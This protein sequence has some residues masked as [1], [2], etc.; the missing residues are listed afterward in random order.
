MN[1]RSESITPTRV[2]SE[3]VVETPASP[4]VLDKAFIRRL[5][6]SDTTPSVLNTEA[7]VCQNTGAVTVTDFSE[8]ATGQHLYMRGDGFTTVANNAN[9]K[10]N[11]GANKLLVVDK[12]YHFVNFSGVWVEQA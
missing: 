1:E 5:K 12:F 2:V 8:G 6:K 4:L 11:T 10:T 3:H 9:I 7:C